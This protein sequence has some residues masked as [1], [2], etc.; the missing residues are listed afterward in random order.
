MR[1]VSVSSRTMKK[2][3]AYISVPTMAWMPL[4][5]SGS[6]RPD[7]ARSEIANSARCTRSECS[8]RATV[9]YSSATCSV[10]CRRWSATCKGSA[11]RASTR[12]AG[13]PGCSSTTAPLRAS[14]TASRA[15]LPVDMCG[16]PRA[17]VSRARRS[18]AKLSLASG[19]SGGSLDGACAAS[20]PHNTRTSRQPG[21]VRTASTAAHATARGVKASS[22][23]ASH[24]SDEA[25]SGCRASV[26]AV[27][28]SKRNGFL[29][30]G[31]R[32][33]CVVRKSA[34][35]SRRFLYRPRRP[36]LYPLS[37]GASLGDGSDRRWSCSAAG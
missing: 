12:C 32:D 23:G 20:R 34:V 30:G 2:F 7:P 9:S 1:P 31:H 8:S 22:N 15:R 6:S 37:R 27:S 25:A 21:S 4:S 16:R 18:S 33:A 28:I 24:V 5:R 29:V 3:S 13:S 19:G 14:G 35:G 26:G 10:P 36:G 11:A 17:R